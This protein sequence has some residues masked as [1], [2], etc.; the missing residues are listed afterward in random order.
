MSEPPPSGTPDLGVAALDRLDR[1]ALERGLEACCGS[2]R[3]VLAVAARQPFGDHATL[4]A[5]AEQ[6]AKAL[7]REDWLE[8]FSHHP[9]IGDVKA[10]RVK[11]AQPQSLVWS[12]GE[13]AGVASA[14]D[15]V[16]ERL[17]AGNA[18]Y[19]ERFGYLFIVRAA[20]RSAAEMLSLLEARLDNDPEVEL[21]IAAVQQ[22][23]I[24]RGRLDAWLRQLAATP[25]EEVP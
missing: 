11:F 22:F 23:E 7:G 25:L 19:E 1:P 13:Q 17:A 16:L 10:L 2:R 12:R 9:K 15:G 21:E 4:L 5:T 20:G 24:T 3:W 8:A 14:D 18:E 6:A